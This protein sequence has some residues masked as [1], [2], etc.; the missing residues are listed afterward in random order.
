MAIL[1]LQTER[2]G[3]EKDQGCPEP[4][5]EKRRGIAEETL[6]RPVKHSFDLE[7]AAKWDKG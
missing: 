1:I 4:R 5:S 2:R 3:G 6:S 7:G